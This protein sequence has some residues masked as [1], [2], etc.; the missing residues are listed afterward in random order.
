LTA[1]ARKPEVRIGARFRINERAGPRLAGKE[2]TIIGR[3]RQNSSIRV[4][5]D[6]SKSPISLH[7]DYIETD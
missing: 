5:L 1:E 3:S 6:G 2:G 4:L 7:P